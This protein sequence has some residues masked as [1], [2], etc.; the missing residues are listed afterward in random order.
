MSLASRR[1]YLQVMRKRYRTATTRHEKGEILDEVTA[2]C[3]YHRKYA[4]RVLSDVR[5]VPRPKRRHPRPKKYQEALPV[6]R[7]VW[8]ALDYPCAERLHP[9]LLQTAEQLEAHGQLHL[10]PQVREQLAQISRATLARRLASFVSPKPRRLFSPPKPGLL[11]QVEVP[12][13]R[14]NWDEDRPGALEVDL[15]EHNGGNSSGQYAYTLSVVDVVTGWSRR[16]AIP[17]RGQRYVH[18]ALS[19]LL[20]EWPYPVWGLHSDNG[21]EFLNHMVFRFAREQG[22][23]FSRSRPY[24]K[25]DNPHVEQRNRQFVREIVGYNRYDTPEQVLW[26]NQVYAVLDPY[27]NFCL[28]TRKVVAK[29]RE[30]V[31]IRKQYDTAKSPY[32]RAIAKGVIPAERQ[33]QLEA[34]IGSTSPLT[35]HQ[36]L[37]KLISEGAPSRLLDEAAD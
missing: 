28:P 14:Y 2:T 6:I 24:R 17:G 34:W 5:E 10:S 20:A 30:G 1:E 15:V 26:L 3:G 16:K 37:E 36:Q 27:G 25:N 31:H 32:Q 18:Q 8:E 23:Q 35:L 7:M 22:L 21:S 4:I 9:V 12:I 19:E 29:T 33:Q 11:R 13:G